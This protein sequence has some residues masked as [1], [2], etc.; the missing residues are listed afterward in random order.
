M[1]EVIVIGAGISGLVAAHRLAKA[2]RDVLVLE[3]SD[4]PGGAIRTETLDGFI[5][6]RGPNSVRMTD[7]LEALAGELGLADELVLADPRA[8]RYVYLGGKLVRAPMGPASI[9]T[10][11]LLSA[12]AKLRV[13]AE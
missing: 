8:P 2:G 12:R 7:G 5:V 6:E 3:S 9:V 10:T 13:L 11:P 4:V 1:P